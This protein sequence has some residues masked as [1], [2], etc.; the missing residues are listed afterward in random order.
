MFLSERVVHVHKCKQN[1][2][3]CAFCFRAYFPKMN[4]GS[5]AASQLA[6]IKRVAACNIQISLESLNWLG[7]IYCLSVPMI[8]RALGKTT[9]SFDHTDTKLD[10]FQQFFILLNMVS[11]RNMMWR[12]EDNFYIWQNMRNYQPLNKLTSSWQVTGVYFPMW[13]LTVLIFQHMAAVHRSRQQRAT[14]HFP[15]LKARKTQPVR[16]LHVDV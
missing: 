11:T 16:H 2:Q 4:S 1:R 5:L 7:R 10:V 3:N 14:M 9:S 12:K 6:D 13:W 8:P 15:P